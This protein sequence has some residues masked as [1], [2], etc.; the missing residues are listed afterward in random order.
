MKFKVQVS[1]TYYTVQKMKLSLK[2]FLSKCDQIRSFLR[3]WIRLLKK[4]FMENFIFCA[5][6]LGFFNWIYSYSFY[7]L[8]WAQHHF[9]A[10][11]VTLLYVE[12]KSEVYTIK[13]RNILHIVKTTWK[14]YIN[15][16]FFL[17]YFLRLVLRFPSLKCKA[18]SICLITIFQYYL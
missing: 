10:L 7:Q 8:H 5:V 3:I 15:R 6:L 17:Q 2:N 18:L 9:S 16:G 11:L 1:A 12:W 4:S 14:V 13:W